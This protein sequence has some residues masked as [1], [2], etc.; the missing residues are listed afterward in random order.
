PL[1]HVKEILVAN[2][3]GDDRPVLLAAIEAEL[4]KRAGAPA[5]ADRTLIKRYRFE[6]GRY[7]GQ[8]VCT[9]PDKLC[10][11]LNAGDVDG[12]GQPELIAS[13]H[14]RGIWL[15]RPGPGEWNAELIDNQSGGFEHAT[16]LGDLDGDG[17]QEIY[18]AADDQREV[19]RYRW[20]DG[21]WQRDTLTPIE[22]DKITFGISAGRF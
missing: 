9:L 14:K 7:V 15:A 8:V 4:G 20:V 17:V 12:D 13:T 10:R 6:D 5:E 2:I 1:R 3:E 16:V 11:F 18:V 22:D 19:R 21:K